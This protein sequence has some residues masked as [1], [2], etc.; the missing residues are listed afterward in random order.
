MKRGEIE[1]GEDGKHAQLSVAIFQTVSDTG[2]SRRAYRHRQGK[3]L[4]KHFG[5]HQMNTKVNVANAH[6]WTLGWVLSEGEW[7]RPETLVARI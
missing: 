2:Q 7:G 1:K 5:S 6:G 4:S 3:M